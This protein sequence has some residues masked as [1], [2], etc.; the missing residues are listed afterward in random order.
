MLLKQLRILV[1]S[2]SV[3]CTFLTFS[4][5]A[6][7][8][9][10]RIDDGWR[11]ALGHA[12]DKEKDFGHALGYFSY[13]A[14]TGYGDGAAS[15]NFD[16]RAWR[17]ISLP[18]DWAVE[19]GFDEKASYSH[20]FKAIGPGFPESSVGWYRRE[21]DI[22]ESDLGKRIRI[23]FDGIYRDAAIFVN[24]F[25]VGQEPSGFVAQSYDISE[26]LN[27]GGKNVVAVRADAYM[28][29]GWYYEGAGIYRHAYL[30]KTEPVHVARY[31][32]FVKSEI[33]G[34]AAVVT[35]D[36]TV[37]NEADQDAKVLVT[38]T[39]VDADGSIV[40]QSQAA[41][42]Q[43][44]AGQS[45]ERSDSLKVLNP[46]LWD[47]DTPHLY[48]MVT[49][50]SSG[51]GAIVDEY[52]T[53]FGIREIRFDPNHG[54]FLNGR[55]V[56]LKGSNN[57]QDHAGIGTAL[58]DAMQ[59]FRIRKLKEMGMNAYRVS[60]HHASP[61]LLEACDRLGMLVIDETR[62]MGINE[63]HF[64]QLEHLILSG[65]NHPSV[66]LWSIGNEE[67]C[68]EG[69]VFGA[70]IAKRM[71]DFA[72]RLDPTRRVTAAVSG[73][74]GGISSVIE[75]FG[76]NY[77]KHGDV[78]R[79]H[80]D[81]PE[82]IILGTEETT[83]QQTRGIYFEDA[84][85]AHQHPRENGSSG[86]NAESG[87]RFYAERDYTAGVF[88]W[89]GFDYRGEPTPYVWPAV[90]SQFGILDSCGFPKDGYYYL[91]SWWTE[92]PV[93]HIFPH[94]NW[95]GKEGESMEVRAHANCD[96]VELF[97]NGISQGRKA[98]PRN[99]HLAWDVVYEPGE[100]LARG[101]VAGKLVSEKAV[102]TTGAPAAFDLAADRDVIDADGVDVSVVTMSVLD[103][104]GDVVPTADDLAWFTI[105][106]PGKIIGVGNGN[107]SSLEPDQFNRSASSIA[108]GADWNA[109]AAW[110]MD[111]PL[112]FEASFDAPELATGEAAFLLMNPIGK[113]LVVTL[114]GQPIARDLLAERVPLESLGIKPKGNVFKM[115]ANPFDEWGARED[116]AE[117]SP[118]SIAIET[119][120]E[121]Y[122]RKAFNGLAQ[123]IVQS[124]GEA[125]AIVLRAEGEGLRA[126]TVRIEA[127]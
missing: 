105:E 94:W 55:S 41:E 100:L 56:K 45:T 12:T 30:L 67:W 23:E 40:A 5:A 10:V 43:V 2:V 14:K 21:L 16:D 63:Y 1:A 72:H 15:A 54:F 118:V 31:G 66:I 117:V 116:V 18:H 13:L 125:G 58:P 89:T 106:G 34:D 109:P 53:T 28:E 59:D 60:H 22:A 6:E 83:T 104:R 102:R 33:S 57:H 25:F 29:E 103:G 38:H 110:E 62:L 32:T 36:T 120:A 91:K 8:T 84:A 71:Q 24:G 47:L 90:L 20:G 44:A 3:A 68:I 46:S 95:P 115:E 49:R 78:D 112:V 87:W 26:Y 61:A 74:W 124:T 111:G 27:Y 9:R 37:A 79:Q 48:T 65:R 99:G 11:F 42:L 4:H 108:I 19:A 98:M 52:S 80:R 114:N 93:L 127:E 73:G 64:D 97:L 50:L 85:L 51:D 119:P 81:Y 82:Q 121:Q 92:E 17:E 39:I 70:R 122:R 76:V 88:F 35:V 101:Y 77:I 7:R 86:G 69:N 75:A 126:A 96:E 123:I 107:P 113:D